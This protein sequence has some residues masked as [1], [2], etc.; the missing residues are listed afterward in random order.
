MKLNYAFL[1]CLLFLTI[2]LNAQGENYTEEIKNTYDS[3]LGYKNL[4]L[5]NGVEIINENRTL[6]DKH[7]FFIDRDFLKGDLIYRGEKYSNLNLRY[8]IFKDVLQVKLDK[9]VSGT[10]L[11]ELIKAHVNSFSLNGSTFKNLVI[12]NREFDSGFYEVLFNERDLS[13]YKKRRLKRLD[14]EDKEFLYYEFQD[15]SNVYILY[16][17]KTGY[18]EATTSRLRKKLPDCYT[19]FS[20]YIRKNRRIR[21]Q[22][23]D[24]YWR[25]LSSLI[26]KSECLENTVSK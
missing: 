3:I 24:S 21:K 1:W 13:L 14:K 16:T 26:N 5:L 23:P 25:G 12:D 19:S 8:D 22:D 4:S 2:N 10:L 6:T 11:M 18:F 15:L 17:P 9:N 7:Q 20:D